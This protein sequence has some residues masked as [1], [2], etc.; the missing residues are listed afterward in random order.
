V[1]EPLIGHPV[2][3]PDAL[4]AMLARP[5][6]AEPLTADDQALKAWLLSH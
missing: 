4:S 2:D 5:A 3:V 1:V 6:I